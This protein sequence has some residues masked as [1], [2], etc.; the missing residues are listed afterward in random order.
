MDLLEDWCFI[1]SKEATITNSGSRMPTSVLSAIDTEYDIRTRYKKPLCQTW[2]LAPKKKIK[3]NGSEQKHQRFRHSEASIPNRPI[4]IILSKLF[5]SS[6]RTIL[7]QYRST[8]NPCVRANALV[9][10]EIFGANFVA[11]I[12]EVCSRGSAKS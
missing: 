7:C 5:R 4:G 8:V 6:L 10:F 11:V 3:S 1:I 12:S 2:K 9:I